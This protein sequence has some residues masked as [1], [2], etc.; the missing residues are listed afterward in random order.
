M[1]FFV[2]FESVSFSSA[3]ELAGRKSTS[4]LTWTSKD[5]SPEE[6]QKVLDNIANNKYKVIRIV[7]GEEVEFVQRVEIKAR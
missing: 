3:F 2:T 7:R 5:D 6:L 4:E 1:K